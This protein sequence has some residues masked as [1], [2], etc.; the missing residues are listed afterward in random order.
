MFAE[1]KPFTFEPLRADTFPQLTLGLL[2]LRGGD[3]SNQVQLQPELRML[4]ASA[5]KCGLAYA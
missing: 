2:S 5:V 1:E 4:P 3:P